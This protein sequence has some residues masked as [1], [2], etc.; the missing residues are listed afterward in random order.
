MCELKKTCLPISRNLPFWNIPERGSSGNP[1]G[2][3]SWM[4]DMS[5]EYSSFLMS[6]FS[7]SSH[8][9]NSSKSNFGDW[10]GLYPTPAFHIFS[11]RGSTG[12]S[13]PGRGSTGRSSTGRGSTGSVTPLLILTCPWLSSEKYPESDAIDAFRFRFR[14]DVF[15]NMLKL[16]SSG[17][18]RKTS[19]TDE[20]AMF[21]KIK[22][23][24]KRKK[25]RFFYGNI[26]KWITKPFKTN[27]LRAFLQA[28][29][30]KILL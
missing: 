18:V 20:L 29:K 16:F 4:T 8:W 17:G 26:W 14:S 15:C 30:I 23:K 25:L 28:F 6:P 12:R 22:L 19:R 24:C 3:F 7:S 11:G 13:S 5:S 1:K 9:I 10:Q 2:E 27:V 21:N